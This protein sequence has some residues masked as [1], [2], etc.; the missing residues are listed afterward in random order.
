[1]IRTELSWKGN[2]PNQNRRL[3]IVNKD[4]LYKTEMWKLSTEGNTTSGQGQRV[5][6][7]KYIDPRG[8]SMV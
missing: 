1:M 3:F 4:I 6:L 8:S 5:G 7:K 2:L